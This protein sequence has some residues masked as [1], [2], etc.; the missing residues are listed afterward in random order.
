MPE[1]S[2]G[3][4]K[5]KEMRKSYTCKEI[6]RNCWN[7]LWC[8]DNIYHH[9]HHHHHHHADI[10]N[11]PITTKQEHYVQYKNTNSGRRNLL[12]VKSHIKKIG[13]SL[14]NRYS[15]LSLAHVCACVTGL[16]HSELYR[17]LFLK[18]V[19]SD[20]EGNSAG[21]LFHVTG[22]ANEKARSPNLGLQTRY[23]VAG[24]VWGGTHH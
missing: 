10:Y 1:L 6:I 4:K 17:S 18:A 20:M 12:N 19:L 7:Q 8:I 2:T 22:P 23:G 24:G 15:A 21:R 14:P 5:S 13:E 11:A 9:H 16:Q 3:A